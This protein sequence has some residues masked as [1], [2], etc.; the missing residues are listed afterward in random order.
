MQGKLT[1]FIFKISNLQLSESEIEK[2]N[3]IDS[4]SK[5][6]DRINSVLQ[7]KGDF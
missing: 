7:T 1:N 6:M 4:R 2:I 5:I 3:L